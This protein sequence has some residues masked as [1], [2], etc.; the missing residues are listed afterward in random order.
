MTLDLLLLLSALK[1]FNGRLESIQAVLLDLAECESSI[2]VDDLRL[3]DT[4]I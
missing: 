4:G 1:T 2:A 3:P